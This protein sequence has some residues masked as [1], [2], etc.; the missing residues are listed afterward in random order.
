[1]A[2]VASAP[3]TEL[4]SARTANNLQGKAVTQLHLTTVAVPEVT[5]MGIFLCVRLCVSLCVC[6]LAC[7]CT[8][9]IDLNVARQVFLA[10]ALGEKDRL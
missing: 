9:Q 2:P 8:L 4:L 6:V 7:E 5:Y 3:H 1:M 10:E